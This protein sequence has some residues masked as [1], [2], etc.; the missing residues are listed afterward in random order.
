MFGPGTFDL[1]PRGSRV[2]LG[3]CLASGHQGDPELGDRGRMLA[4]SA[5]TGLFQIAPITQSTM[6]S[7]LPLSAI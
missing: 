3:E 2:R 7:S 4:D 1:R 5:L 6:A